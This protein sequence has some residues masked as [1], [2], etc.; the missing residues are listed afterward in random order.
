MIVRLETAIGRISLLVTIIF[1][2]TQFI[3][4]KPKLIKP[5]SIQPLYLLYDNDKPYQSFFYKR[6]AKILFS[7]AK[8]MNYHLDKNIDYSSAI[9]A[10]VC[11]VHADGVDRDNELALRYINSDSMPGYQLL[12][13]AQIIHYVDEAIQ[14]HKGSLSV[15]LTSLLE[16]ISKRLCLIRKMGE[17]KPNSQPASTNGIYSKVS[18]T[19]TAGEI[20]YLIRIMNEK[21]YKTRVN[22]EEAFNRFSKAAK[23]G[24]KKADVILQ[25]GTVQRQ[26]D[27]DKVVKWCRFRNNLSLPKYPYCR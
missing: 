23:C 25:M 5:T 22:H 15:L 20:E 14:N 16:P 10:R 1:L 3:V 11:H 4:E 19:F 21:G 13:L 6:L 8:N 17:I 7:C 2:F 26:V 24:S 18:R 27:V 9:Y 12:S